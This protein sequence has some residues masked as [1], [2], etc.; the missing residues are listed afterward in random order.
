[1]GINISDKELKT[2]CA[3]VYTT[4]HFSRFSFTFEDFQ[5]EVY[6]IIQRQFGI[7]EENSYINEYIKKYWQ[8]GEIK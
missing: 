4:L 3:V 1:M 7:K 2:C 5:K 6:G 8:K